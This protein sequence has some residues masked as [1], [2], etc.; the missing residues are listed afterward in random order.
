MPIIPIEQPLLR[1]LLKIP[2]QVEILTC[3]IRA[4][5]KYQNE[6][7]KAAR[8]LHKALDLCQEGIVPHY[9]FQ[10]LT[11]TPDPTHQ[12]LVKKILK[13]PH[14]V[15]IINCKIKA[16]LKYH[17]E[18]TKAAERLAEALTHCMKGL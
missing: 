8:K 15:D 12:P 13:L 16:I 2:N 6:C 1:K 18:C 17:D 9:D 3:Q 11:A 7:A 5:T 4:I 10:L 14:Q